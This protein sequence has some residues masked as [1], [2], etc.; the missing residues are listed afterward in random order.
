MMTQTIQDRLSKATALASTR[1][2]TRQR[3]SAK[4]DFLKPSDFGPNKLQDLART[5]LAIKAGSLDVSR[6][7][8][9]KQI[10][11][12]FQKTSTRTRCSFEVGVWDMGGS[13]SVIDWKTSNFILTDL[14]DEIQVISR[15]YDLVVARVN[16]HHDLEVMARNAAVPIVNGLS[17]LHHPCQVLSDFMTLQEYFGSIE[18]LPI[19]YVG[20]GNNI[21]QS[22]I[23]M[24]PSF[25]VKLTIATPE[26]YRP[27]DAVFRAAAANV[28]WSSNPVRAV[29]D[30]CVIY[31]DTWVSMGMES[32][33]Q[34]RLEAFAGFQVNEQLLARAPDGALVMHCLPAHPG[35]EISAAVLRG[36][37]SIVLDQAENRKFA[38]MALLCSLLER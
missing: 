2:E 4:A 21:C 12:L 34:A 11:L 18:G 28:S 13:P 22:L 38:Q 20:D 25:G 32:E 29:R 30:A 36:A 23:E 3:V 35:E 1:A 26:A 5:G 17:D 19:T 7:L 27:A 31:T 37:R 8:T 15:Y 6:A 14:A 33:R 16:N 9:G 24:A 10:A